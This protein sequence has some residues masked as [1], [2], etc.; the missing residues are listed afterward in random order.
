MANGSYR[1]DSKG[2]YMM[3]GKPSMHLFNTESGAYL[4]VTLRTKEDAVVNITLDA[5]DLEALRKLLKRRASKS[6][7]QRISYGTNA[8]VEFE[9][10]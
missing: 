6:P 8:T 7:L 2:Y 3:G 5:D 10:A 1:K 4:T 9:S